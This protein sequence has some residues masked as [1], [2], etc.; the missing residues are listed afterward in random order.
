MKSQTSDSALQDDLLRHRLDNIIS[1][2]HPLARVAERIDWEGMNNLLDEYYEEAVVGQP[3][4]P[5]RLMAGLL[6]LKQTFALS[7]E[8]LIA[9]WVEN[10]CWEYF[11]GETYFQHLKSLPR[12]NRQAKTRGIALRQSC[13]RTGKRLAIKASRYAHARQYRLMRKALKQLRERLGRV[14][15]GIER[16]TA[17]WAMQPDR[18]C[19]GS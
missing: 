6:Y 4:K 3:P 9:R 19:V 5:A 8:E 11:C 12:L 16:K 18:T 13:T 1:L 17:R 2:Q 14:V 15:R 10:S 7:D